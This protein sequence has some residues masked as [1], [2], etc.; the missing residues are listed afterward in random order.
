M[1]LERDATNYRL[2]EDSEKSNLVS[3]PSGFAGGELSVWY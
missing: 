3:K 2:P 1:V